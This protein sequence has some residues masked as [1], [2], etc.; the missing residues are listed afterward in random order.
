MERRQNSIFDEVADCNDSGL[1]IDRP[2]NVYSSPG[3]LSPLTNGSLPARS[4][5]FCSD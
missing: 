1:L 5:K 4:I 2:A 3:N